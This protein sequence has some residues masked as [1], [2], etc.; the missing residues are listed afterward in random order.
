MLNQHSDDHPYSPSKLFNVEG[1]VAVVTG[2]GSGIGL[3]MA[4]ALENNGAIVYIVGRRHD[5]LERAA[6]ENNVRVIMIFPL[7]FILIHSSPSTILSASTTSYLCRV[8]SRAVN[9]FQ[10]SS[11]L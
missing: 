9:P 3:M 2:G 1:L 8:M 11:R 10:P 6:Q 5:V 4:A 7:P